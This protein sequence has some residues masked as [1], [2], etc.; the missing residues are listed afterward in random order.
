MWHVGFTS[1]LTQN[2]EEEK[3]MPGNCIITAFSPRTLIMSNDHHL[4]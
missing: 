4:S 2:T 1:L 3:M